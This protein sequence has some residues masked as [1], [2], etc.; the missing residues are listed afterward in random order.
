MIHG[1][2]RRRVDRGAIPEGA[3]RRLQRLNFPGERAR[4]RAEVPIFE[5]QLLVRSAQGR[6]LGPGTESQ[7]ETD[8]HRDDEK[9]TEPEKDGQKIE[10]HPAI[11][12]RAPI[13]DDD[14][15]PAVPLH[16]RGCGGP[17]SD[18]RPQVPDSITQILSAKRRKI[19]RR[20]KDE[21][22][23]DVPISRAFL[24]SKLE[25]LGH[26]PSP[27]R[28]VAGEVRDRPSDSEQPIVAARRQPQSVD[29]TRRVRAR[30]DM[31]KGRRFNRPAVEPGVESPR[32]PSELSSPR[33]QDPRAHGRRALAVGRTLEVGRWH[34]C[35]GDNQ[36]QPIP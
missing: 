29:R 8:E 6:D 24:A 23:R 28:R 13:G 4:G 36:I 2:R 22:R 3:N 9:G 25:R 1:A 34:R 12:A 17:S 33:C 27:D 21:T 32:R 20:T 16:K 11:H 35:N 30:L 5:L 18:G 14:R 10:R 31:E 19:A 7:P 26:M 15:I